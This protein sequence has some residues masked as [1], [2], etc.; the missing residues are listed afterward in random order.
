M[1]ETLM[2]LKH[3]CCWQKLVNWASILS[4]GPLVA[5]CGTAP[6]HPS[7]S[8]CVGQVGFCAAFRFSLTW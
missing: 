3:D 5:G 8:L 6:K 2:T 7:P 1:S 4:E